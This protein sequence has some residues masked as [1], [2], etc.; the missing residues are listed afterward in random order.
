MLAEQC[1]QY[2]TQHFSDYMLVLLYC[3]VWNWR[4]IRSGVQVFPLNMYSQPRF[5]GIYT[6]TVVA[7]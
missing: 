3:W 1:P 5:F 6:A 7:E 4:P 2:L